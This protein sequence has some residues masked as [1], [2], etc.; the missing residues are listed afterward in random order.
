MTDYFLKTTKA[1][2]EA[3]CRGASM[4]NI[5]Q[6]YRHHAQHAHTDEQRDAAR[7]LMG[8]DWTETRRLTDAE[9]VDVMA[10]EQ[11]YLSPAKIGWRA[12]F[13][14]LD[15]FGYAGLAVVFASGVLAGMWLVLMTIRAM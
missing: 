2:G 1:N 13:T 7:D 5:S 9:M 3:Y 8:E 12:A 11:Y 6:I 15:W 4:T 14:A 10:P